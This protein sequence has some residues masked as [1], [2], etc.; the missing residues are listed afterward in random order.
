[1]RC[2]IDGAEENLSLVSEWMVM[3]SGGVSLANLGR[4]IFATLGVAPIL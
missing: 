4:G 2:E 3:V 1:M